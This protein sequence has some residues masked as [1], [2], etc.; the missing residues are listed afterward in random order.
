[1]RILDPMVKEKNSEAMKPKKTKKQK[2]QETIKR[3]KY[4]YRKSLLILKQ[5]RLFWK[6][7]DTLGL[8]V[9]VK[10][11]AFFNIK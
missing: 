1:M 11:A 5:V 10:N 2:N 4:F 9:W 3:L 7:C 6:D 8:T